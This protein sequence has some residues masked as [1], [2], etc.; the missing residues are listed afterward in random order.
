M[1][2][3]LTVKEEALLF[4]GRDKW[5]TYSI[6]EKDIPSIR[7]SDGPNGL[8]IEIT[9]NELGFGQAKPA[10]AL[11]A[12]SLMAC[13]FDQKLIYQYGTILAEEC[14]QEGIDIILGPGACHKRSPL[15]GRN[16]EYFSEDPLLS[17]KAAAAY[18]QGVQS[19]GIGTSLKHFAGNSRE[20]ARLV[21]D[22]IIDERTLHEIYLK[23]FMIA[24]REGHPWT[25]MTAY[26]LLNGTYCAEN[27]ELMNEARKEGF[28]GAFISDWGAVSDPAKSAAAGLSL[29]M[30]GGDIGIQECIEK[31]VDN[32]ELKKE[33]LDQDIAYLLHTVDK[34]SHYE[35]KSYDRN[36]HLAFARKAAEQSAVLLKNEDNILPLKKEESIALIGAF[37]KKPVM[38]AAGSASVLPYAEDNLYM[39]LKERNISF[40][41][42]PGYGSDDTEALR[43]RAVSLAQSKDRVILVCGLPEGIES[44]GY[45]RKNMALP[46]DQLSLIQE[47]A[48]V[49]HNVIIVLEC[50]APVELPFVNDVK[51]ILLMYLA[52]CQSGKACA[53]LLYGDVNPSGRLAETWPYRAEDNPSYHNFSQYVHSVQY[54]EAIYTGY[55]YYDTF[56][57]PVCFPFGYG[58]SY[59]S[60]SVSDMH[61]QP[62]DH[63]L[64]ITAK[65]KN[66]GSRDGADVIEIFASMP[67]SGIA[68]EKKRL[69][70][71]DKVYLKAGEEKEVTVSTDKDALKYYDVRMH[72]MSLEEGTY[73]IMACVS[74]S[75]VL[76]SQ[77]IYLSGNT[78]P[79]STIQTEYFHVEEDGLQ[80]RKADF[81]KM[82]GKKIPDEEEMKPFNAD[83]TIGEL[84]QK[85]LGKVVNW[86]VHLVV[87]YGHINGVGDDESVRVMPLRQLLFVDGGS[88]NLVNDIAAYMNKHEWKRLHKIIKEFFGK[89]KK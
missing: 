75:E 24:I 74:V 56:D 26:N 38:G 46:P 59:T 4:G 68:R 65:V 7:T 84:S 11:P 36:A 48:A 30:P 44:E 17:G 23:Q 58:L 72:Q 80:V 18:I 50:G 27:K 57:I 15:C 45:D 77:D 43:N 35:R 89:R 25:I 22:S 60:F 20:F 71:F 14:M 55:R 64:Q 10:T 12:A 21:A 19:K 3:K 8:R 61:V 54:R 53:S 37:A 88:W 32:G 66:T 83:S 85:K 82:L 41:Y 69:I 47:V 62:K 67:E 28:D 34:C 81:E 73:T 49:N 39:A 6:P 79:Y 40:Q 42:E 5:C 51:G 63:D 76:C 16:F 31:A 13:S 9:D 78:D 87:K 52:G 2:D 70:G 1:K 33:Q 29:E 86:F